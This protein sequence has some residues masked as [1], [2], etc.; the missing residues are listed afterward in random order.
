MYYPS[1]VNKGADQLCSYCE[2]DL[3]LCFSPMQF[4]G[5]PMWWLIYMSRVIRKPAICICENNGADMLRC[6]LETDQHVCFHYMDSTIFLLSK[7][8]ISSLKPIFCARKARFVWDLFGNHIVGF[9][10]IWLICTWIHCL[11]TIT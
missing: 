11:F 3:C 7:S 10:M 9:L 5:F 2:A 1:S 8:K 6:N 4:V